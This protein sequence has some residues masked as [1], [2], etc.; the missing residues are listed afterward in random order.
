MK[1]ERDE[2]ADYDEYVQRIVDDEDEARALEAKRNASGVSMETLSLQQAFIEGQRA[3]LKGWGPNMNEYQAGTPEHDE[4]ERA[5]S[6]AIGA[7]LNGYNR[8]VA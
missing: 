8:R 6:A 7:R 4:W 2:D 3:G 5:R 1:R